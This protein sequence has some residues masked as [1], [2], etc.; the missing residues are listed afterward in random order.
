MIATYIRNVSCLVTSKLTWLPAG[1][2]RI[3]ED[4]HAHTGTWQSYYNTCTQG[5]CGTLTARLPGRPQ[6][7]LCTRPL[8][9]PAQVTTLR[10]RLDT[11]HQSM[12]S[13]DQ[14]RTRGRDEGLGV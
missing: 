12:P 5:T 9:L 7:S 8:L 10:S 11:L 1:P 3:V 2:G 13:S 6:M 14:G 4:L